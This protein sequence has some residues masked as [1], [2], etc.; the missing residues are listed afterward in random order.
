M[1]VEYKI[2]AKPEKYSVWVTTRSVLYLYG[3]DWLYLER[4]WHLWIKDRLN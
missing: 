3:I 2:E 4:H 1:F